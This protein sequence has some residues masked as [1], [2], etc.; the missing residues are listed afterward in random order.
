M[1]FSLLTMLF[2]LFPQSGNKRAEFEAPE[3]EEVVREAVANHEARAVGAER[4]EEAARA[5]STAQVHVCMY[6]CY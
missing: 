2:H 3:V 1:F 5:A 4:A 6:V